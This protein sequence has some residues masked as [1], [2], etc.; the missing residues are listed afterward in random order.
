MVVI[1]CRAKSCCLE[2]NRDAFMG[3]W[4]RW[5]C[6]FCFWSGPTARRANPP[7]ISAVSSFVLWFTFVSVVR[8]LLPCLMG[9]PVVETASRHSTFD[10]PSSKGRIV[11]CKKENF[12]IKFSLS[13]QDGMV[14]GY[15]RRLVFHVI[16][17]GSSRF[18]YRPRV[19]VAI[20]ASAP[21]SIPV[22]AS[23]SL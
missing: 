16:N 12:E 3:A 11:G 14:A 4:I 15:Q 9:P 6:Y 20:V 22:L 17:H 5:C 13:N 18:W 2:T 21:V 19:S 10:S 8:H 7:L 1:S 23:P